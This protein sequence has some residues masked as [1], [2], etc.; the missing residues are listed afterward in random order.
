[1]V[2]VEAFAHGLPVICSRLGGMAEVVKDGVSGLHFEAGN[3]ADLADKVQQLLDD[4]ERCAAMGEAARKQFLEYY[5][6]QQNLAHLE[7]IY[8]EA[9][10][11]LE[12]P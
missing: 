2:I 3:A 8:G 10:S 4:P 9:R 6:P 11:V 1:M 7:R 12:L 5:G